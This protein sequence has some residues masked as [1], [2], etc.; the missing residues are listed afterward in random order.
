MMEI[1]GVRFAPLICYELIFP[2]YARSALHAGGEVFLNVSNDYWFGQSTEPQQHLALARMRAYETG[3]PILRCANTGVSALIDS[4][5]QITHSTSVW[6]QE[7][8]RAT[9]AIP[10]MSWTPYARWGEFMLLAFLV[11]ICTSTLVLVRITNS[12]S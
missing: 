6:R 3:R 10:K 11:L 12:R 1:K 4:R 7:T 8:L 2:R 9:L 5:G